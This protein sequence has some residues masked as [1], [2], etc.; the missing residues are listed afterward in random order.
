MERFSKLAFDAATDEVK[1]D[2]SGALAAELSRR[3]AAEPS[4]HEGVRRLIEELRALGHDLWSYDEEDD[5]E[6]W[7]PDY[8]T[9][10]GPG[11]VVTFTT[12]GVSVEYSRT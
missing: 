6:A 3:L 9:P 12:H 8:Q 5:M 1:D 4:F 10:S 7:G 2:L 11:I